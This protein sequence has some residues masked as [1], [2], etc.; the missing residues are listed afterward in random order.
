MTPERPILISVVQY[1]SQLESGT[2]SIADMVK[3]AHEFG[4]DG[5]E[6]RREL[7]PAYKSELATVRKQIDELG[8]LVTF[9]TF[10]TIFNEDEAA[11]QLLLEDIETAAALGSPLLRVFPG[12]T[13]AA[14]G[15]K[16]WAKAREAVDHAAQHGI[17][18]ALENFARTPG[19]TLAEISHILQRIDSPALRAN[20]DLGNYSNHN[21]NVLDAIKQIGEKAIYVHVKDAGSPAT[22]PLALGEGVLPLAQIFAAIDQLPQR[23]LLC[24]EFPGGDD[25]DQHIQNAQSLMRAYRSHPS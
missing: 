1:Q 12:A 21:E 9:A 13:P 25:P 16:G 24:F 23:I 6:L 22:A 11:H 4:V 20:I 10:S 8:L 7:W 19:G 3:K 14:E 18:L 2:M 5:V 15:D 17:K